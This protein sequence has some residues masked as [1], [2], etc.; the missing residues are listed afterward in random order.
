MK[1]NR[2]YWLDNLKW[3]LILLVVLGHA[4]QHTYADFGQNSL[5]RAIYSFHM[6]AFMAVSGYLAW[7]PKTVC[8]SA[9]D[10]LKKLFRR[11]RQL[12]IPYMIWSLAA[13]FVLAGGLG[14]ADVVSLVV[15]PE[16]NLWFLWVLFMIF[17]CFET[18][19]LLASRCPR[20]GDAIVVASVVV[21][22]G[23]VS[24]CHTHKFGLDSMRYYYIF[25]CLGFFAHHYKQV[26]SLPKPVIAALFLLWCV[27]AHYWQL[28]GQPAWAQGFGLLGAATVY[29]LFKLIVAVSAILVL[30]GLFSRFANRRYASTLLG[31]VTLGV[32]AIHQTVI[33]VVCNGIRGMMPWGQVAVNFV[34]GLLVSLLVIWVLRRCRATR[35]ILLGETSA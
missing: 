20:Y 21:V 8:V 1:E 34:V 30:F 29:S 18:V 22:Y 25:Y 17:V 14:V 12:V 32:Y 28:G 19:R 24:L 2:I 11:V 31:Q 3:F 10:Y 6:P 16:R 23:A 7:K 5:F 15:Y 4:I 9:T 27:G 33:G 26:F 35:H 13:T